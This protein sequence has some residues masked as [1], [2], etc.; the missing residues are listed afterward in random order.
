MNR[1]KVNIIIAGRSYPL[2]VRNEQE[3]YNLRKSAKDI[4]EMIAK[5]EEKYAVN[6]KQDVLAMST[7]QYASRLEALSTKNKSVNKEVY[8]KV[9]EFISL[10]D[11]SL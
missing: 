1:F 9:K 4:N 10:I 8:N 7:L 5:L 6:D 3:E 2:S 11:N